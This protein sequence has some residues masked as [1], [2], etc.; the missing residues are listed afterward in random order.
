MKGRFVPIKQ[1]EN[2][3][4]SNAEVLSIAIDNE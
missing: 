1:A 2:A 3:T 4:M